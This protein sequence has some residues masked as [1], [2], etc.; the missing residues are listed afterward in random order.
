VLSPFLSQFAI[1]WTSE[2]EFTLTCSM[3]DTQNHKENSCESADERPLKILVSVARHNGAI[4][5]GPE[6]QQRN[7]ALERVIQLANPLS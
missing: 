5:V 1:G 4:S 7:P 6:V 2:D 3:K